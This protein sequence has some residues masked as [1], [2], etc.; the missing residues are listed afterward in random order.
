MGEKLVSASVTQRSLSSS[1]SGSSWCSL[2][3]SPACSARGNLELARGRQRKSTRRNSCEYSRASAALK[4]GAQ[5]TRSAVA[6]IE[7]FQS[8][9][10]G[11]AEED[12]EK[13]RSMG[14]S[15]F[16]SESDMSGLS[17]LSECE[18]ATPTL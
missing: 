3:R 10:Q 2:P 5:I 11:M 17:E 8:D 14:A 16:L 7:F 13:R 4:P 6:R 1:S 18:V 9:H 12:E 15:S